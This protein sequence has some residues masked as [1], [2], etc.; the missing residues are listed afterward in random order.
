[1]CFQMTENIECCDGNLGSSI[2]SLPFLKKPMVKCLH[3]LIHFLP[4]HILWKQ[5][6][7]VFCLLGFIVW[8]LVQICLYFTSWLTHT[9]L[10][11]QTSVFDALWDMKDTCTDV[12]SLKP[13]LQRDWMNWQ[14]T[15]V[16]ISCYQL[17]SQFSFCFQYF[18]WMIY[19]NVYLLCVP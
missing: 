10:V 18:L 8:T 12:M 1:M 11:Q 9:V 14:Q 6:H 19:Y 5:I 15:G 7:S 3:F 17:E 16:V 4:F 2:G 13:V